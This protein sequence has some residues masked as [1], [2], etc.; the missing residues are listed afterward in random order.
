MDMIQIIALWVVILASL[1]VISYFGIKLA[2]IWVSRHVRDPLSDFSADLYSL[3]RKWS[4]KGRPDFAEGLHFMN[5]T[6][7]EMPD[8]GQPKTYYGKQLMKDLRRAED[9]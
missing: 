6:F 8:E 2:G 3:E 7:N 5:R 1:V 4:L 9:E